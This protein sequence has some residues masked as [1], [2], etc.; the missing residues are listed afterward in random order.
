M[1]EKI[2]KITL[3]YKYYPGEDYYCDGII[4]DELLDIVKNNP[5]S[6]FQKIIEDRSSWPILYHLS[7]LRENIVEWL[8][9]TKEM[10]V[11]EVGSG[12]GAI[13]G[14]LSAKAGQVT[15]ID[16]SKKRSY[17]N[18]YRHLECENVTIHVGNFKDIEQELSCDY[19]YILLIGVFEYGQGYMG[20]DTPYED[21]LTILKKH[22]G[23]KGRMA[24]AI[25]NKFGLKYWAGCMEDHVGK[26]FES[27]EDY[28]N[29]GGVRT[30]T[31][32]GLEK[33]M[34]SVG[35]EQY[36]F[37]FPYPDYKFPTTFYSEEYLP[38]IG[39]LSNNLR[40]FDRDRMLL[41]DEKN[42]FD[43]VIR[44]GL[45][46]LYSNSYFLLIGE[47][48]S[49]K[50]VKYSNDRSPKYCIRT[51]IL[52]DE[53]GDFVVEKR[54][55]S[56]ESVAHILHMKKAYEELKVRYQGSDLFMNHCVVRDEILSFEFL[57]GRTLEELFDEL[58]DKGD[59][60]GFYEL[61]GEYV[62]KIDYG[63]SANIVDYDLVFG[64]IIVNADGWNVI[65]YEW[66]VE[67]AFAASKLAYRAFY[68]Y[69]LGS[70]KRKQIPVGPILKIL[71]MSEEEAATLQEKE[72]FFQAEV[73]GDRLPMGVI[74]NKIG[75]HIVNPQTIL[76]RHFDTLNK[77]R[78]QIYEDRGAGFR[79]SDSYFIPDAYHEEGIITFSILIP[80]EVQR[81]RVD[82]AMS[83]GV[84]FIE[85][86]LWNGTQITSKNSGFITNGTRLSDNLYAFTTMDPNLTFEGKALK[87]YTENR[88]TVKMVMTPMQEKVVEQFVKKRTFGRG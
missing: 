83:S 6:S 28:P 87:S 27:I 66:T 30:F 86:M 60:E 65:D 73:T 33:I 12:C 46:P 7:P 69:T 62:Q 21:F 19:D 88:L 18:A 55:S 23:T 10:K 45:F 35:I 48:I 37:Y 24:I 71:G 9:I 4:E 67:E 13:T 20:T 79:E 78:V 82:P 8:P 31:K 58:L 51:D 38:K 47:E 77:N 57:K 41:F 68:C 56:K 75:N 5:P 52:K 70:A 40:N 17:I 26:Y 63:N 43:S 16:L 34:K 3:D 84:L 42:A 29:G 15:C 44:E 22:L 81:L 2:G 54:P 11:L 64:N 32:T 74:R 59:Y 76:N 85:D 36:S 25:E 49:T 61:F 39:E 72:A 1:I 14:A 80:K 53:K 50:F